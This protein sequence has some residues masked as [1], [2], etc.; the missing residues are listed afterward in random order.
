[1]QYRILLWDIDGTVL[2]FLEAE[3]NAI[4]AL[5]GK[6]SLGEC[7]DAMLRVYSGINRSYWEKLERGEMAKEAILVERFRDFFSR[8]GLD[9]TCAEM[10]NRD[11]Q[12][13]LG[14]TIVFND[15]A[16]S[17]LSS[18]KPYYY[19]AAVTNG[20]KT[21]Q[22]KKLRLSGLAEI[23][24]GIFISED[25]G[26]EKPSVQYFDFVK[27]RIPG[28][29]EKEALII[30]DSLTSDILG[31]NN[32]GIDTCWYNPGRKINDHKVN[33]TFEIT[34]LRELRNILLSEPT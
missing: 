26:F 18:L 32:A 23:F 22:E 31:G 27:S 15:D 17:L 4:R 10:F 6:Y 2:N 20:T 33:V 1:M 24:D 19:Q 34:D 12:T 29:S 3:K 8:Y 14:D 9:S 28:F 11:Y 21:A 13:A 7:T 30:G 16:F 5:F 25:V